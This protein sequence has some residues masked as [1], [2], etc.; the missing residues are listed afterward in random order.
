[1][2]LNKLYRFLDSKTFRDYVKGPWIVSFS[3]LVAIPIIVALVGEDIWICIIVAQT[4]GFFGGV[5]T[6]LGFG[7][8]GSGKNG[9]LDIQSRRKIFFDSM[10]LR[11]ITS[12]FVFF[13][14]CSLYV[15][16]IQPSSYWYLI[17]LL[18]SLIQGFGS[19]WYLQANKRVDLLLRYIYLPR[20]FSNLV[21]ASSFLFTK[22]IVF[23][24]L[25][26]FAAQIYSIARVIG[27][28][29]HQEKGIVERSNLTLM[30]VSQNLKKQL[31]AYLV[32]LNLAAI[33]HI[34]IILLSSHSLNTSYLAQFILADRLSKYG[35][36][37]VFPIVQFAQGKIPTGN[38]VVLRRNL[39]ISY[40]YSFYIA[41]LLTSGSVVLMPVGAHFLTGGVIVLPLYMIVAFSITTGAFFLQNLL[42]TI[43]LSILEKYRD[44]SLK[45]SFGSALFL[46]TFHLLTYLKNYVAIPYSLA[47]ILVFFVFIYAQ[48]L[49]RDIY[50]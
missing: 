12:L 15:T 4:Y 22:N 37:V 7:Y 42:G 33:N 10:I 9:T 21:S 24:A 35:G 3:S 39:E 16:L 43:H 30:A 17:I 29:H 28:A 40:R 49:R 46:L 6:D 32:T 41:L 18:S 19:A 34:P 38:K 48:V 2:E 1:M 25:I 27:F 45:M 44:I 47:G 36:A 31:P 26:Y 11:S 23:F 14:S 13:I 5:I 20:A 50:G 8:S